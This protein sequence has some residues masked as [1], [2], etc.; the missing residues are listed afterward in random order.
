MQKCFIYASQRCQAD[1]GWVPPIEHQVHDMR[2]VAADAGL[3][4]VRV[5]VDF[6]PPRPRPMDALSQMM[7]QARHG[8]A[9]TVLCCTPSRLAPSKSGAA[10][11]VRLFEA[12]HI[13]KIITLGPVYRNTKEGR[14]NLRHVLALYGGEATDLLD[15][16]T[17]G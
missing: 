1:S 14:R 5:F 7:A 12:G 15:R 6:D 16:P 13:E 9:T 17:S 3:E 2:L 4:V 10:A 11:I 8:V